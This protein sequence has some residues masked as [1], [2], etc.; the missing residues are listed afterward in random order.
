EHGIFVDFV[1]SETE[2]KRQKI[3]PKKDLLAKAI[4][5]EKGLRVCDLTL[6]LAGDSFK[7]CHFG[8]QIHAFEKNKALW[9]LSQNAL[10]R[11]QQK[12]NC[13]LKL[14]IEN[15]SFL[16]GID[17]QF[18]T[19]DVFYL[20]PMYSHERSALP[21]KEMQY[22]AEITTPSAEEELREVCEKI[23]SQK[24]KLVVKRAPQA[25]HICGFKPKRSVEGKMVR[26]DVY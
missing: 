8:V 26:F 20:D 17:S 16:E 19:T 18:A 1:E 14:S 24:K 22:L 10:W 7:L 11:Y 3:S 21:R 4:G 23:F 6:G 5:V 2:F 15:K 25:Q 12:Q 9:A 13:E